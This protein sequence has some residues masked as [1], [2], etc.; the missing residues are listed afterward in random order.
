MSSYTIVEVETAINY[1]RARQLPSENY[2]LSANVRVLGDLYGS[3]IYRGAVAIAD[4]EV[5]ESQGAALSAA[6]RQLEL[7]LPQ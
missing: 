3:M 7:P 4:G 1:W 2:G 5:S 6:L